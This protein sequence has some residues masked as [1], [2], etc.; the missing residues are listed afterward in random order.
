[1]VIQF[2]REVIK[3]LYEGDVF[4]LARKDYKLITKRTT[5]IEVERYYIWNKLWDVML[6]RKVVYHES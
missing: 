2:D 4:T 5:V 1:M 6:G 3:N